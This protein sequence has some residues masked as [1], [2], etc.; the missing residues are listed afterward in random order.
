MPDHDRPL[1]DRHPVSPA[2]LNDLLIDAEADDEPLS[3]PS[4]LRHPLFLLF[5]LVLVALNLRPALSSISPLLGEVSASLHLS[6]AAAGL[7]TTLPVLCLGLFAPFAPR[8]ARRFG[9]E[10]V[11]LGIL[12]LLA[13]G[14][15]LRS[16]FAVPGL[17]LSLIH[18]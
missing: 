10:R 11:I 18:I 12:L 3:R 1:P 16:L 8:L 9:A 14:I 15:V 17:F 7:L 2:P 13:I 5:G 4:L 6:A